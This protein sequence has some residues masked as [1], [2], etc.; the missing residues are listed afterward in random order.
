MGGILVSPCLS[1]CPP[2]FTGIF[3]FSDIVDFFI[4]RNRVSKLMKNSAL[5]IKNVLKYVFTIMIYNI[6]KELYFHSVNKRGGGGV[7]D[8]V[9]KITGYFGHLVFLKN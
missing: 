7:Q 5:N 4:T 9:S 2:Y 8:L 3:L 1:V 6:F